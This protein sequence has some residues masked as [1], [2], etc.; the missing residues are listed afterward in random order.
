MNVWGIAWLKFEVIDVGKNQSQ[1]VQTAY[2][3]PRGLTGIF[4]WY[5][6]Y[7]I[8]NIVFKGL[9]KAIVRKAEENY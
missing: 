7:P 4:Y 8:H 5:S 9:S 6:V 1:L 2:Y 3:Y